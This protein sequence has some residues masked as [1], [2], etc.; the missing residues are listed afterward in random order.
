MAGNCKTRARMRRENKI[1]LLHPPLQ[2]EGRAR[3]AQGGVMGSEENSTCRPRHALAPTRRAFGAATSP[4][5]GEVSGE[6][7]LVSPSPAGGG[8]RPQGAG[9]GYGHRRK[10]RHA[11]CVTHLPPPAA[12]SARRPPPCRGRSWARDCLFTL[13]CRGRVA[14]EGRGVGL[15]APK[16]N[17]ISR[18][19]PRTC[20]HPPRLRRGDLPLQGEVSGEWLRPRPLT[21][22]RLLRGRA[23][24]SRKGRGQARMY[25][26]N[27][28]HAVTHGPCPRFRIGQ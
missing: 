16:K 8:S 11:V 5:Q 2:G 4:L 23:A 9:W 22:L 27:N 21:R 18:L 13:P 7:L 14:P 1:V 24:L 26:E 17:S 12:P 19:P 20:P 25:R 6:G 10:T 15:W 3:R 28:F